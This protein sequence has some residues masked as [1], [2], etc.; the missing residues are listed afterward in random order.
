M[1][2]M[3]MAGER[4]VAVQ[5]LRDLTAAVAVAAAAGVGVIAW[6]SWATIPGSTGTSSSTGAPA[7]ADTSGATVIPQTGG[8]DDQPISQNGGGLAQAPPTRT[9][10]G[11]G[12]VVSGGSR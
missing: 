12:V 11:Q 3:T 9:Q 8:D 2:Q 10:P 1:R 4:D 5:K 6:V 7:L